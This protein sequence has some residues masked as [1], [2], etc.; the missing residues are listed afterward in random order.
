MAKVASVLTRR[1]SDTIIATAPDFWET[2][3]DFIEELCK[4]N[5]KQV[6]KKDFEIL[7]VA[8]YIQKYPETE[9]SRKVKNQWNTRAKESDAE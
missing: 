6:K 1:G 7:S 2:L 8:S 5:K 9:F 3:T 4:I